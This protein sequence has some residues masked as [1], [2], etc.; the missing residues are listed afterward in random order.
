MPD[1]NETVTFEA[2]LNSSNSNIMLCS[3]EGMLIFAN[4]AC[5]KLLGKTLDQVHSLQVFT[6]TT[7]SNINE[8]PAFWQSQCDTNEDPE[9]HFEGFLKLG[10]EPVSQNNKLRI[11]IHSLNS[12]TCNAGFKIQIDQVFASGVSENFD[13]PEHLNNLF[14]QSSVAVALFS[15]TNVLLVANDKFVDLLLLDNRSINKLNLRNI[16]FSDR[17]RHSRQP[18]NSTFNTTRSPG[19]GAEY[20]YLKRSDQSLIPAQLTRLY[21]ADSVDVEQQQQWLFITPIQQSEPLSLAEINFQYDALFNLSLDGITYTDLEGNY[22]MINEAFSKMLRLESHE[23]L[24]R[25]IKDISANIDHAQEQAFHFQQLKSR[26]YT[27]LYEQTFQTNDGIA[28]PVTV[29]STSVKNH[30]GQPIGIWT[31]YR[32]SSTQHKLIESLANSERR[33]RSLF[34][35]SF[36]AIALYHVDGEFQYANKAFLSLLEIS[37]QELR[38]V[39]YQSITA[40]GWE[41]VDLAMEAQLKARG[42]TDI[43]EKE[44]ST[45][46]GKRVP[47]SVRASAIQD[48]EGN[49]SSS[50]VIIRDISAHKAMLSKLQHSQNLLKQTSRMSRV[51]AWELDLQ[52]NRLSLTEETYDILGITKDFRLT[53][54]NMETIF[55]KPY[56]EAMLKLIERVTNGD[57]PEEIELKMLQQEPERWLRVSVQSSLDAANKMYVF[58]AVQDISEFK[59]Q[60]HQLESARDNYQ[61][62]AFHDPLTGLPNRTLLLDRYQQLKNNAARNARMASLL[63]IDL[64]DFKIINDEHGHPTGDFLLSI[65]AA[66][67]KKSIRA[68]D[69]V[70]RLG[71][72][73]FVVIA[74]T[75][76]KEQ[77]A[78]IAEKI[79]RTVR[80]PI[81][82]ERLEIISGCTIGISIFGNRQVNFETSYASADKA[83]YEAKASGKG[84]F[85]ISEED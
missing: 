32:D 37:Q 9:Y 13:L 7:S 63:I 27:D 78:A 42:Y 6:S 18:H 54:R 34:S 59:L 24:H 46:S 3:S 16:L 85:K 64:D 80:Q 65:L 40:E 61:Q 36:D 31:I 56:V 25:N 58:G 82:T 77:V 84:Q 74:E 73:E 81:Q 47:V 67:L 60:Q 83:L 70:A 41:H 35:R 48:N 21:V 72:D 53:Q 45:K 22:L 39:N 5:L 23:I 75:D 33:F 26:G 43:L 71:G 57:Q 69:T 44:I 2:A 4:R 62:L 17:K 11:T 19:L 52:S 29:R 66:R 15:A 76:D 79:I 68:S 20:V 28:V 14:R 38:H 50:W 49:Y 10:D 55:D 12:A 30:F 1:Q 8:G 51:G